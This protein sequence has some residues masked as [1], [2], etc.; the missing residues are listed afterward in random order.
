MNRFMTFMM[1]IFFL[2]VCTLIADSVFGISAS[3]RI[4]D[5]FGQDVPSD[6]LGRFAIVRSFLST[7]FKILTFQVSGMPAIVNIVVFYPLTFGIVYMI[8]DLFT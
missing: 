7:F 6:W 5:E 3:A 2:V 1:I 8:I 4:I